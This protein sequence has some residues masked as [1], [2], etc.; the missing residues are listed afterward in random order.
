[1]TSASLRP[2]DKILVTPERRL[3]LEWDSFFERLERRVIDIEERLGIVEGTA[4]PGVVFLTSGTITNQATLDLVLTSYTGY[5][6][7]KIVLD[8]VPATDATNPYF[9]FSSDGGST[10]DA[11]GYSYASFFATDSGTSG[12]DASGSAN[13]I[14]L[15]NGVGNQAA[16][17]IH[18]EATLLSPSD[19]TQNSRIM[20]LGSVRSSA[21]TPA[22]LSLYGSGARE[23]GQDTDA[24]RF[25]FSS[26]NITSGHYAL[27]GLKQ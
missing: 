26:G 7:Y 14:L 13:Q 12:V 23:A 21:A 10:F 11:T 16:E 20:W 15:T 17:G 19:A 5:Y 25:L 24:V 2:K 9:R 18:I 8:A 4:G 3:I 6:G 27:Y 1:M 22:T